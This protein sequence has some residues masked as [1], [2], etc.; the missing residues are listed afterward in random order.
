MIRQPAAAGLPRSPGRLVVRR[1]PRRS[2]T[3]RPAAQRP[4][5]AAGH[6]RRGAPHGTT[7]VALTYA[8]GV[9]M[10]GDRRATMGN[11]IAQRD[12]E[13]VFPADESHAASASPAPPASPSRWSGCSRS[14]SSTTRRSR[15]RSCRSTARPTG[16]RRCCAATS[17][18]RCRASP[19]SRCSP[20]TTST[21][22]QRPDLLLRRHRRPLRGARA[23]T[24]V[25]SGSMFARGALKKLYA[26]R[27]STGRGRRRSC[28]EALVRR[29]RRR[30][31]HRRPRPRPP[32]LPGRRRRRR[33][34]LPPGRPRRSWRR[35]RARRSWRTAACSARTA[36]QRRDRRG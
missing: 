30:L 6:D 1:V 17:A 13:K 24:R 5:A 26:P 15:A 27:T 34:R 32:D 2:T 31:R 8:D 12:I 25:G 18:W 20:A 36:R 10:A 7:I 35:S 9:V 3:P 23:T 11:V 28:V 21:R 19:S 16:S 29:R 4:P 33:R 14:S 22:E